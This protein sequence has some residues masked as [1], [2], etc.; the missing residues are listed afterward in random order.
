[1]SPAER[2]GGVEGRPGCIFDLIQGLPMDEPRGES[3][4]KGELRAVITRATATQGH[5]GGPALGTR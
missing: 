2:E 1:M 4:S 3:G 5:T